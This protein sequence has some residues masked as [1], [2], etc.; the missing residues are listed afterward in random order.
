VYQN[1][2]A[3]DSGDW[4]VDQDCFYGAGGYHIK[5]SV[6]CF[7]P[8]GTLTNVDVSVQVKQIKG[9]TTIAYGIILRGD[10]T[11]GFYE[12]DLDS[13]SKWLFRKCNDTACTKI[14]D[15]T[16]NAAIQGGLNT[17]NTMQVKA[18]GSHFDFFVNGTQVGQ[19]DDSTYTTGKV[20]LGGSD[21]IEV[22]YS[23]IK[24]IRPNAS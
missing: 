13:N 9:Q 15:F 10:T 14:V 8:A 19:A 5:S 6:I 16:A 1:T 2:L 18:L 22:V 7:A 3:S 12:Y 23:N 4:N 11:G 21:N 20:G 24:I 17:T